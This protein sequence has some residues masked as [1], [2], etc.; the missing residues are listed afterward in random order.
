MSM[1]GAEKEGG[2]FPSPPLYE[3]DF[4]QFTIGTI[5]PHNWGKAIGLY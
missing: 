2:D 5:D 3:R 4:L 1:K